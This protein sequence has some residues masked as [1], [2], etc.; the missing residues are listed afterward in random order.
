MK[1]ITIHI[2]GMMCQ[3]CVNRVEAILKS[4]DGVASAAVDLSKSEATIMADEL[5]TEKVLTEAVE[6]AGFDVTGCTVE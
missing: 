1:K 5:L 3:H 6:D 4:V 2:E